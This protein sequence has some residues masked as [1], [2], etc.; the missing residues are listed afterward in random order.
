MKD[1]L[2]MISYELQA[3]SYELQFHDYFFYVHG[4]VE[5]R[6][7]LS[8]PG[9]PWGGNSTGRLKDFQPAGVLVDSDYAGLPYWAI[10]F[11][12]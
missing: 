9:R 3:T 11:V 8:L 10:T 5:T 2:R 1:S 12:R 4:V 6:H 7:A